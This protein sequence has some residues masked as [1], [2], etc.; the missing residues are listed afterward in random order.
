MKEEIITV[1][2]LQNGRSCKEV[3]PLGS[4]VKEQPEGHLDSCNCN[5]CDKIFNDWQEAQSKLRTF[6]ID[7]PEIKAGMFVWGTG[8]KGNPVQYEVVDDMGCD[9]ECEI[10]LE[11]IIQETAL[12]YLSGSTHQA[13]VVNDKMVRIV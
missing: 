7:Y 6:E 13:V 11:D 1:V 4:F 3:N 2:I 5:V 12:L 8:R 10:L 9:I